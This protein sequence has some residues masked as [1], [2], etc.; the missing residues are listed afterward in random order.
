MVVAVARKEEEERRRRRVVE[1]MDDVVCACGIPYSVYV[2]ERGWC[3]GI[4]MMTYAHM[5]KDTTL[6]RGTIKRTCTRDTKTR[7]PAVHRHCL[8]CYAFDNQI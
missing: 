5:K 3:Y 8:W 4:K 2:Y 7:N 1:V 6:K